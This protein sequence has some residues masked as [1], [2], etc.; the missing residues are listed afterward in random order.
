MNYMC[1]ERKPKSGVKIV[2]FHQSQMSTCQ[3]LSKNYLFAPK[4]QI[5][6]PSGPLR[7][8]Q[9]HYYNL[10]VTKITKQ[11]EE[12]YGN[13]SE[14]L[15]G[16]KTHLVNKINAYT[17]YGGVSFQDTFSMVKHLSRVDVQSQEEN[18]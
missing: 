15:R 7:S 5:L 10:H 11:M 14:R 2:I 8:H 17:L 18:I 9:R 3:N 16:T 12:K 1:S 13:E 6:Q 4:R